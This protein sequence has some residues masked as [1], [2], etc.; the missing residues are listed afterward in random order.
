MAELAAFRIPGIMILLALTVA[1]A[2]FGI[3]P[4][5]LIL[6]VAL[7]LLVVSFVLM[8]NVSD[9]FV[10]GLDSLST[11][12]KIPQTVIGASIAAIG[13]SMPELATHLNA[14]AAGD[15][16]IGIGTIVGSAIFNLCAIIG[17][18]AWVR[19]CKITR[20][21]IYRD[22]L[23]YLVSVLLLLWVVACDGYTMSSFT[24]QWWEPILLFGFYCFY[25]YYLF[26]DAGKV[27]EGYELPEDAEPQSEPESGSKSESEPE[28]GSESKAKPGS[29]PDP[30]LESVSES[31]PEPGPEKEKDDEPKELALDLTLLYVG[32]GII[33]VLIL[34]FYIVWA[35]LTITNELGWSTSVFALL[36]IA[37]GTSIPDMFT[38]VQAAR[39]GMGGLAVSNAVGSNTFDIC[40][41][42]GIP[43]ILVSFWGTTTS[44]IGGT[45]G[46]SM[47]YL[48]GTLIV[49]IA[50]LRHKWS[51]GRK[52]ALILFAMYLSFIPVLLLESQGY[53][54]SWG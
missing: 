29:E 26:R 10:D 37:L 33:G 21:V 49:T 15:H 31:E 8:E 39:K 42:M 14:V 4:G 28:S 17:V 11:R 25:I 22:G 52:K 47:I 40:V 30:G 34:A 20:S 24:I 12:F 23:F 7:V 16:E 9:V 44:H 27:E 45:L 46:A 32:G 51:V 54:P 19:E 5:I 2:H 36:I 18:S 6:P 43:L 50:L 41:G 1:I 35:A 38:S 13:S 53:L 3:L 48:L